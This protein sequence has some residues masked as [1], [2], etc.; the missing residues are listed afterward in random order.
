MNYNYV[1]IYI[2][3]FKSKMIQKYINTTNKNTK[4]LNVF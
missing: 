1:K 2:K 3:I 4:S